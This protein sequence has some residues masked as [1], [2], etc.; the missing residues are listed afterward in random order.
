MRIKGALLSLVLMASCA[1]STSWKADHIHTGDTAY[2]STKLFYPTRDRVNGADVEILFVED[3]ITSYLQVHSQM[4]PPYQGN[5]KEALVSF[6]VGDVVFSGVAQRHEGGQR[7]RLT[8]DLQEQLLQA[9]QAKKSVQLQLEGYQTLITAEEF[10]KLF[11]ESQ[12]TPIRNPF[13]LPFKL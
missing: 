8:P 11:Q 12:K 6:K 10:P 7:V 3:H 13:Q 1:K 2:N 5:P 4:I 9:L